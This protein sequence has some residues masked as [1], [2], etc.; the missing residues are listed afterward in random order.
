MVG[1]GLSKVDT[2]QPIQ[3]YGL[4]SGQQRQ[5]VGKN[6]LTSMVPLQHGAPTVDRKRLADR[7][8]AAERD[9]ACAERVASASLACD[10]WPVG[11]WGAQPIVSCLL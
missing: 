5:S 10:V 11:A 7:P 3:Y 6:L 9:A 2:K 8:A 1:L 4:E